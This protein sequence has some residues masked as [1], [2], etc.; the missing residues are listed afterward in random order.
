MCVIISWLGAVVTSRCPQ[1]QQ[2]FVCL[3][4]VNMLCL[5]HG[6]LL[7]LHVLYPSFCFPPFVFACFM[8]HLSSFLPL[9]YLYIFFTYQLIKKH[10]NH[11][12]FL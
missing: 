9:I 10:T 4:G 12:P 6:W 8:I 11:H 5:L 3:P 2:D 7:Q 1:K